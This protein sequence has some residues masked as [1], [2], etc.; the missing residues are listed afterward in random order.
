[1]Q[2]DNIIWYLTDGYWENRGFARH[3]YDVQPGGTLT[4]NIT[5]LTPEGQQLALWALD[6]WALVMGIQFQEVNHN[7]ANI[8]FYDDLDREGAYSRA[9]YGYEIADSS[10]TITQSEINVGTGWLADYGTSID[11]Y[12]FTT[13]IHEIGHTLGLGHPGDYN[14]GDSPLPV[15]FEDATYPQ[16]DVWLGTV[17]SYFNQEENPYFSTLVDRG[18]P[19]TPMIY[20]LVAIYELYGQPDN[21]MEGDTVYGYNSNTGTYLDEVFRVWGEADSSYYSRYPDIV[22]TIFD[23]GG[24][25]LLNF[26]DDVHDQHINLGA[27]TE[28]PGT[29]SS[30]YG[31]EG[32]LVLFYY[33][34]DDMVIENVYAGSG[35]DTVYG[36]GADNFLFGNYGD[37]ILVGQGGNDVLIGATG[38]DVLVGDQG[39]DSF[40]FA[41]EG[42]SDWDVIIDFTRGEDKIDLSYFANIDSVVDI[43]WFQ[44]RLGLGL[45]LNAA[46]NLTEHGGGYILLYGYGESHL[47]DSDF[48]FQDE[49]MVA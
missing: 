28:H 31:N 20:D 6:S 34:D 19:V 3:T 17:M 24:N 8:M 35:D 49:A 45:S 10:W 2:E 15:T 32:N 1:M 11:S 29:L 42:P 38:N 39:R 44:Y 18:Y 4:V 7:S 37:D 25:D 41:P 12:S 14:A 48:I 16:D 27:F 40:V 22:A 21:V 43:D 30:I 13:Y 23:T 46:L 36:N 33:P 9:L 5:G 26:S 47:Y